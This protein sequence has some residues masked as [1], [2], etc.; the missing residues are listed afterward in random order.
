MMGFKRSMGSN[1]V[2]VK[3]GSPPRRFASPPSL[4]RLRREGGI[5]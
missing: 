1:Y 2:T 3:D 5:T 4:F